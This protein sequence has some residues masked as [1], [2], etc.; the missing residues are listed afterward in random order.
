MKVRIAIEAIDD[1][2]EGEGF[3]LDEIKEL[4]VQMYEEGALRLD[5]EYSG[6][7]TI[8]VTPVE[9]NGSLTA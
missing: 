1:R 8:T 4:Y 7:L 9:D 6:G 3:T 2:F 5:D